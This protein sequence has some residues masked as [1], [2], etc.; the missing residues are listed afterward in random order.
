MT[1]RKLR[2]R[3]EREKIV[4]ECRGNL[5]KLPVPDD[6]PGVA[7]LNAEL[8]KFLAMEREGAVIGVIELPEFGSKIEYHLPTRRIL[9]QL[10]RF[11][12]LN[13]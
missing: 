3:E 13:K 12:Q 4:S 6:H 7:K 2:N 10:V 11:T 5:A 1:Q 8:E 9:P